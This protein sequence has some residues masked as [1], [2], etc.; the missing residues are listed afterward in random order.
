VQVFGPD[1][2]R[3]RLERLVYRGV[4]PGLYCERMGGDISIILPP[5]TPVPY[6]K[7]SRGSGVGRTTSSGKYYGQWAAS[8]AD[9]SPAA[10]PSLAAEEPLVAPYPATHFFLAP[11]GD[12]SVVLFLGPGWRLL[13]EE[14]PVARLRVLLGG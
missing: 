1:L 2:Q 8:V 10:R 12:P 14:P 4:G 3:L 7:G 9:R 11:P 13:A 6:P 5:S